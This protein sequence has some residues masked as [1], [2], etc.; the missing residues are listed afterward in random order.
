MSLTVGRMD[1]GAFL[2]SPSDEA[3]LAALSISYCMNFSCYMQNHNLTLLP[4]VSANNPDDVTLTQAAI[5]DGYHMVPDAIVEYHRLD[6][7]NY[8]KDCSLYVPQSAIVDQPT[9]IAWMMSDHKLYFAPTDFT[10][11]VNSEQDFPDPLVELV[12]MTMLPGNYVWTGSAVL[13]AV[14]S[15][16]LALYAKPGTATGIRPSDVGVTCESGCLVGNDLTGP[17]CRCTPKYFST[18]PL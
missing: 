10:L 2:Q 13:R 5:R 18:L 11:T 7:G 1:Y 17:A 12:T 4:P 16:H 14:P 9:F 15:N 8:L 6:I 3:F